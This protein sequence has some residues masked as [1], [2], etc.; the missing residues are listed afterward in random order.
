MRRGGGIAGA[1]G[2]SGADLSN[3][4]TRFYKTD[5]S[6]TSEKSGAGLGLSFV[7]NIL[8]LHKQSVWVESIDA[9]EGSD[10]KYTKFTFTLELA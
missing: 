10:V 8:A 2:I 6:R 4:F 3:V 7:K 9:K 5:K 1:D